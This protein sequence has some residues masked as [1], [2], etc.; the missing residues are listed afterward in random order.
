M[1]NYKEAVKDHC[2][3][4]GKHRGM[5]QCL[6]LNPKIALILVVFH[7]LQGYDGHPLMQAM[8]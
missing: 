8:A 2:H 3:F 6:P 7:N 1:N 5:T 4:T